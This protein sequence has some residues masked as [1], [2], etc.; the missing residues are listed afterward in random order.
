MSTRTEIFIGAV[1]LTLIAFPF[2]AQGDTVVPKV[3]RPD[4]D[5]QGEIAVCMAQNTKKACIEWECQPIDV[6]SERGGAHETDVETVTDLRSTLERVVGWVQVFFYI[7]ATLMII[8]A[9]W[10]YLTGGGNEEKIA[11]AKNKVIYALVAIA[12]AVIAGGIV[13]L[14]R[15]FVG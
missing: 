3:P 4:C 6:I 5:N 1:I 11:S 15:N 13:A 9:A 12:I 10:E 14:V 2:I 7:V 8:L